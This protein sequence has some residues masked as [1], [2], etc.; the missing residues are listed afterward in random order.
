MTKIQRINGL[1]ACEICNRKNAEFSVT[2]DKTKERWVNVCW[3]C[4]F[5][6]KEFWQ[7]YERAAHA[8]PGASAPAS[9]R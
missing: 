2:D 7:K 6:D 1:L 5:K 8:T 4:F 9:K 3:K